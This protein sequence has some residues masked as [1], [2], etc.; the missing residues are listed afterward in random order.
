MFELPPPENFPILLAARMS[1]SFPLLFS[2]IP[3]WAIDYDIDCKSGKRGFQRC[4]FSDGGIS[5]NFP[6]HLFEGLIPLWPTFGIQ[7]APNCAP[8]Q[9]SCLYRRVT[10]KAKVSVGRFDENLNSSSRFGGFWAAI[11]NTM[12]TGMTQHYHA[13]PV[14]ETV[15]FEYA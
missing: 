4:Q 14:F 11:V 9:T 12:Q 13:C 2:T 15:A 7:L 8:D 6:M 10:T 3:L 5:S 1:L